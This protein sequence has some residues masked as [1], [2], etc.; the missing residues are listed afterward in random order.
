[1]TNVHIG[2]DA[3]IADLIKALQA[4]GKAVFL[5]SGGFR[6]IINPIA[7]LLGI[8]LDHVFANNILH[9]VDSEKALICWCI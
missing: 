1:M 5:V 9:Q 6:V 3:G 2:C 4:R 7:E 8:P